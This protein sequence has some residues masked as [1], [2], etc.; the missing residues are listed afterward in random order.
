MTLRCENILQMVVCFFFSV[1][2]NGQKM[3]NF[4]PAH[5]IVHTADDD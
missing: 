3:G 2:I 4:S 5:I 1:A